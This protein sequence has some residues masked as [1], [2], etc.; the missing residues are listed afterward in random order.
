MYKKKNLKI[1]LV[2][3]FC[4]LAF[5]GIFYFS[6]C[7]NNT[8]TNN[9]NNNNH[10][11]DTNVIT[12]DSVQISEYFGPTSSS[13]VNLFLGKVLSDTDINKDINMRDSFS[14]GHNFFLRSG[15]QSLNPVGYKCLFNSHYSNMTKANFDTIS[16]IPV[17]HD[18]LVQ[19]DF[20]SLDTRQWGYFDVGLGQGRVYDFYLVGKFNA[21][22]TEHQVFGILYLEQGFSSIIAGFKEVVWV[23][24]NT[25]GR[26]H[27][28]RN[29]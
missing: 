21:N 9:N 26:N 7:A 11:T 28:L 10:S 25:D 2:F 22:Q 16:V 27:F 6:S 23:R 20:P 12:F 29:Y 17:G 3:I 18:P 19:S 15:D 13:A 4:V 5:T 24:I 8:V 1:Q 14:T